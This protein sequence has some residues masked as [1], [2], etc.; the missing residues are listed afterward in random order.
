MLVTWEYDPQRTVQYVGVSANVC[1]DVTLFGE[2][3]KFDILIIVY[4]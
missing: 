3:T 1:S 2:Y 4:L